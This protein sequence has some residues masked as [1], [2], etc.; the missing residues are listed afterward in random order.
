MVSSLHVKNYCM[1]EEMAAK[2]HF[3]IKVDSYLHGVAIVLKSVACEW[4]LMFFLLLDAAFSYFLTKFAQYCDLQVPCILCSRLDHVFGNEKPDFYRNLLCNSHKSELSSLVLCQNHGK[5]A[6]VHEMCEECL[7][8]FATKDANYELH[9]ILVGKLQLDCLQKPF[10]SM[11]SHTRACSCCAKP[12]RSR[13]NVQKSVQSKLSGH[14]SKPD[15]P[16][17]KSPVHKCL[18]RQEGLKKRKEKLSQSPFIAGHHVGCSKGRVNSDSETDFHFS[19]EDDM[20]NVP[21]HQKSVKDHY[22]SQSDSKSPKRQYDDCFP[23]GPIHRTLESSIPIHSDD[24]PE[25][26]ETPTPTCLGTNGDGRHFFAEPNLQHICMRVSPAH[27]ESHSLDGVPLSSNAPEI[28]PIVSA[29]EGDE[30]SLSRK[31]GSSGFSDHV[32]Y[33]RS[34]PSKNMHLPVTVSYTHLT[35]PTNR[36]V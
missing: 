9:K 35:L 25:K 29:D 15:I 17:P 21:R 36:E 14:V 34:S 27:P 16:L 26:G 1:L 24:E 6:D 20:N 23:P 7:L 11:D 3:P 13:P 30:V 12:W 18:N 28:S 32:S 10:L 5:L 8:S 31:F 4:L 33:S 19:D 22:L 2:G